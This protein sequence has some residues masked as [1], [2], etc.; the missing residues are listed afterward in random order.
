MISI[1]MLVT[2]LIVTLIRN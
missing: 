1:L 2:L